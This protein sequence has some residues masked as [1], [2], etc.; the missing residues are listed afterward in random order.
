[1]S[2]GGVATV[3]VGVAFLGCGG[4]EE[5]SQRERYEDA[6]RESI[7][8]A[9]EQPR[10]TTPDD[11][12]LRDQAAATEEGRQRIRALADDLDRLDPPPDIA[13]AH[14]DFVEGLRE[15]AV[16]MD[17]VV[18]AMRRG[19]ERRVRA[20]LREGTPDYFIPPETI[21]KLRNARSEFAEQDYDIPAGGRL[22]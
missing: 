18:A 20:L 19:E 9:E 8:R 4:E 16:A 5:P 2:R 7:E 12:S 1:M 3:A 17:P 14:D 22:P 11:A 6:F 21:V 13:A 10:V 15:I